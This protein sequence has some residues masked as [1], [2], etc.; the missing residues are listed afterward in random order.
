MGT[1]HSE[2][3]A[4]SIANPDTGLVQDPFITI[5]KMSPKTDASMTT[6]KT[7]TLSTPLLITAT[8]S[9]LNAGQ[10]KMLSTI[11]DGTQKKPTHKKK[12]TESTLQ[13]PSPNE[14]TT[15]AKSTAKIIIGL[16]GTLPENP[17]TKDAHI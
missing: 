14:K 12:S 2:E 6:A 4:T 16:T 15:L 11:L 5:Q 8:K 7:G 10:A 1:I 17:T 9:V 13:R 3:H